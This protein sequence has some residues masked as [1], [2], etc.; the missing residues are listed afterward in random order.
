M[1]GD[2]PPAAARAAGSVFFAA[3]CLLLFLLALAGG[4]V[5]VAGDAAAGGAA[6]HSTTPFF[7][8]PQARL[9]R[10]SWDGV[11]N[12]SF[13]K[14]PKTASSSIQTDLLKRNVSGLGQ[15]GQGERCADEQF[16]SGA[17]NMV[18]LRVPRRHTLS[19][20]I[21]CSHGSWAKKA[22]SR[23][24][25]A[26]PE[27][28]F[29]RDPC[30]DPCVPEPG[31]KIPQFEAWL[32]YFLRLQ[33][34]RG[35]L[36]S[37]PEKAL[38]GGTQHLLA[39]FEC[40]SPI[41][42]QTRQLGSNAVCPRGHDPHHV[43]ASATLPQPAAEL[44]TAVTRLGAYNFVGLADELFPLSWCLLLHRLRE[45]LDEWCF[46]ASAAMTSSRIIHGRANVRPGAV[47]ASALVSERVWAKVD[48]LTEQDTRVYLSAAW[49]LLGEAEAYQRS[50]ERR[51]GVHLLNYSAFTES[52]AY[53]PARRRRN[54]PDSFSL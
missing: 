30:G 38:R 21:E 25:R 44:T 35:F 11:Q 42:L 36:G 22:T 16:V 12:K 34:E 46:D 32:D 48:R 10:L 13:T 33:D 1:D 14:I 39:D 6:S 3:R 28:P 7:G 53:I 41:E 15:L 18:I 51:L 9:S 49:R 4:A 5:S 27:L 43:L 52:V 17:F 8:V 26:H 50:G 40:Y 24:S 54:L 29:P 23:Y 45:P 47:A 19:L 20:F 31:I 2:G 37:P